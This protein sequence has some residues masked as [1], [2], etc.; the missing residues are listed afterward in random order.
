MRKVK[1]KRAT[2]PDRLI[3][4]FWDGSRDRKIDPLEVQSALTS[5]DDFDLDTD[6]KLA[7]TSG[8]G[9][10]DALRRVISAVQCAFR[11]VP[12]DEG[13]PEVGLTGAECMTL[14]FDFAHFVADLK[15]KYAPSLTSLELTES[16][17]TDSPTPNTSDSSSIETVSS[18]TEPS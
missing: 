10:T 7:Q 16:S 5:I 9:A 18:P 11:V 3:F 13:P 15:K 17:P 1:K 6:M 12:Y 8:P 14:L 2:R 4:K